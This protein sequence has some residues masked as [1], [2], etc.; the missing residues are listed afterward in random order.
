MEVGLGPW[1]P[2][3]GLVQ[4]VRQGK[5]SLSALM[6]LALERA[7]EVQKKLYYFAEIDADGARSSAA[8]IDRRRALGETLGPLAGVPVAIKDC[9]SVR[10]L[11][12]RFGS[13]AMER[14]TH[15]SARISR[16]CCASRRGSDRES[17]PAPGGISI[18]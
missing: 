13:Q 5:I 1:S 11:G 12:N 8:A 10:K 17:F 18:D 9:T 15:Y 7:V 6:E 14:G 4:A 2:V 16:G 3:G